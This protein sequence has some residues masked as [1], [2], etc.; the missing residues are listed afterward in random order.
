MVTELVAMKMLPTKLVVGKSMNNWV[1]TAKEFDES[2]IQADSHS[3]CF[4]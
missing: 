2:A 1:S 3:R 4:K